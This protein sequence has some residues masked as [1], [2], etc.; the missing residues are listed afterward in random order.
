MDNE[1]T[2]QCVGYLCPQCGTLADIK[3]LKEGEKDAEIE[4]LREVVDALRKTDDGVPMVPQA[5]YWAWC[6]DRWEYDEEEW[7][8]K[9][10][11]WW[12][13]GGDDCFNPE[14]TLAKDDEPWEFFDVE[15]VYSTRATAEVA[16]VAMENVCSHCGHI[17][18]FWFDRTL[19]DEADGMGEG[20]HYRCCECGKADVPRK[21]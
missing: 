18:D 20:M 9:E 1:I 17:G 16:G 19:T 12:K 7:R 2:Q 8:V 6:R 14:F 15:G 5:H 13:G 10:V 4:R 3:V 21:K 11:I